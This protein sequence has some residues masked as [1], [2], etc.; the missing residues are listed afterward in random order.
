MTSTPSRHLRVLSIDPCSKGFGFA[1]FEGPLLLLDWG[2]AR[3]LGKGDEGFL[4]RIEW[5][6]DRYQPILIVL[7]GKKSRRGE[8]SE[9]RLERTAKLA[10][11]R[12]IPVTVVFPVAVRDVFNGAGPT[13]QDVAIAIAATFPELEMYLPRKRKPWMAEDERMNLFDAVALVLTAFATSPVLRSR[14]A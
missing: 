2:V 7:E 14:V 10:E 11:S 3:V 6:I 8:R 9:R 1:V 12:R 4:A 5:M 13:K